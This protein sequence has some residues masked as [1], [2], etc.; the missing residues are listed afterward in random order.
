MFG[1]CVAGRPVQL[2]AVEIAENK[3]SFELEDAASINHF[4]KRKTMN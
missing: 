3:F 2:D 1:C 4:V